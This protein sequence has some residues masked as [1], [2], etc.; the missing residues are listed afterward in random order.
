VCLYNTRK[1]TN[2]IVPCFIPRTFEGAK[3]IFLRKD[4]KNL[5]IMKTKK[6]GNIV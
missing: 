1:G 6:V 5:G 4:A 2:I 3:I